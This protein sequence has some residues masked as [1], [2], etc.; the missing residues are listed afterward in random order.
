MRDEMSYRHLC[1]SLMGEPESEFKLSGCVYRASH[2]H[3][4]FEETITPDRAKIR[5]NALN[6]HQEPPPTP[7]TCSLIISLE[8]RTPSQIWLCNYKAIFS[9]WRFLNSSATI[10]WCV[11]TVNCFPTKLSP[12][13]N[14]PDER[15]APIWSHFHS[16]QILCAG[17]HTPVSWVWLA[18]TATKYLRLLST[19]LSVCLSL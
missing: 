2:I 7:D 13:K 5:Q 11:V 18:K 10:H 15:L 4:K 8:R 6:R 1:S 9:S 3:P 14:R 19:I 16:F 17:V 12:W